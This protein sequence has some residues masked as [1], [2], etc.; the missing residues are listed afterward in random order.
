MTELERCQLAKER[1]YT[2]CPVSGEIKGVFGKVITTKTAGYAMVQ[3]IIEGKTYRI[4]GH[5]F[6]WYLHYG[7]LPINSIDHIDGNRSNNKIDNLRD[8]TVQQNQWNHTKAK[9]YSWH[10]A[11]NKFSSQIKIDGKMKH[12]GLFNTEQEA[13]NSYL[14]AKE[15]Y[16]VINA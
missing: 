10:K 7:H 12:L 8:V 11:S 4:R 6:A 5:R 16:H 13:R 2:Y 14:K 9:G 1:G 15:I 3:L